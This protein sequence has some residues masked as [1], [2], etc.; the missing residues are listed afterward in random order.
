MNII[1]NKTID[2]NK[3]KLIGKGAYGTVYKNKKDEAIKIMK[4]SEESDTLLIRIHPTMLREITNL[5]ILKDCEYIPKI[6]DIYLGDIYSYSM[7][8]YD[9]SIYDVLQNKILDIH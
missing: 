6:Y 1:L 3:L 5:F 4:T 2:I 9:G 7:E 8:L